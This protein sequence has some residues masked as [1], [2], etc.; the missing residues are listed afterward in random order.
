MSEEKRNIAISKNHKY[1]K[2]NVILAESLL[3][4]WGHNQRNFPK[5]KIIEVYNTINNT[6]VKKDCKTC[7]FDASSYLLSISN[8]SKYGRIILTNEGVS[9]D[10]PK[11][12]EKPLGDEYNPNRI[13]TGLEPKEN[14]AVVVEEDKK[15]EE[16]STTTLQATNQPTTIENTKSTILKEEN[17]ISL[18]EPKEEVKQPFKNYKKKT[19][20]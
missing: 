15:K 3:K 5:E 18:E 14:D 4:E 8:Y 7:G 19:K 12:V 13:I 6:N 1:T 10:K 2:E 17:T 20:K 16:I 11:E 9:F